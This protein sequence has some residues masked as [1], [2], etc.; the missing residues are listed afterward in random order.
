MVVRE[1]RVELP[2][3]TPP[4]ASTRARDERAEHIYERLTEGANAAD[5]GVIAGELAY[6]L[7]QH[8]QTGASLT[9]EI[10]AVMADLAERDDD[11]VPPAPN[12]IDKDAT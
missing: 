9:A 2:G 7:R 5:A 10:P 3:E 1:L 11:G 6:K 8:E 12:A 4:D